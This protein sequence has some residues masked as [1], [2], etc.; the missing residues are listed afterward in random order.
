MMGERCGID[1]LLFIDGSGRAGSVQQIKQE[2]TS[3]ACYS[4]DEPPDI[5]L[6]ERS[7][8]QKDIYILFHI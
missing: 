2:R 1:F 8:T 3:D 4:T 7:Q 5:L 6:S